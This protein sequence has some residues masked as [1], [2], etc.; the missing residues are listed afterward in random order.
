M[1][2]H[3]A[4]GRHP[5]DY[6]ADYRPGR[7]LFDY[8]VVA[9]PAAALVA[10]YGKLRVWQTAV[11]QRFVYGVRARHERRAKD[12]GHHRSGP[13]HGH[14]H[15]QARPSTARAAIPAHPEVSSGSGREEGQSD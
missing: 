2:W 12:N 6:L 4:Q 3:A 14:F 9:L 7:R 15:W 1:G 8:G 10:V 11:A 13:L 5:D